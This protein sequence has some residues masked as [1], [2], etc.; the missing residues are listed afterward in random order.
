S[1]GG[2]L[3]GVGKALAGV[4]KVVADQFGNLLQAG[5]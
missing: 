4:G 5:Q 2:F 3:K 1:L